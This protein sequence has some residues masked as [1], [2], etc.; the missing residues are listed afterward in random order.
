MLSMSTTRRTPAMRPDAK[1]GLIALVVDDDADS[2]L[3]VSDALEAAG[4]TAITARDG[5]TALRLAARMPPDIILLDAVMPGLDGFATCRMIKSEPSLAAVPVVFMTGL[6]ESTHILEG[7]RAGGVDY[8]TKPLNLDEFMARVSVHL[9]NA[10]HLASARA[11]L[12]TNGRAAAAFAPDGRLSWASPRGH[13]L[14]AGAP[15]GLLD[16]G[17]ASPE[18]GAWLANLRRMPLS[19]S[20]RFSSGTLEMSGLGVGP[21]QDMHVAIF[22]RS[23]PSRESLLA[24]RFGL[25]EREAEVLFW[26]AQGKSNSDIGNILGLSSRTVSKHLEQVFEKMGVDNRTSAAVMADRSMSRN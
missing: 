22:D 24:A 13:E 15:R 20:T 21:G 9:T 6:N 10:L 2:L 16:E 14:L 17:Y 25:T 19:N 11:A 3:M 1:A 26:L 8:I 12:D 23:G 4:I 5:T 7:L 18:L